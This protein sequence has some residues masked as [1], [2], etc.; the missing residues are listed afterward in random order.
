MPFFN[1]QN[2]LKATP[3][4]IAAFLSLNL[5][6]FLRERASNSSEA[7]FSE[8][9]LQA[10]RELNFEH[11]ML[12]S[13]LG[14]FKHSELISEL[15]QADALYVGAMETDNLGLIASMS[16]GKTLL[17]QPV[18]A[19]ESEEL[20]KLAKDYQEEVPEFK[21][22][23]LDQ[24]LSL[25][26]EE[27]FN[28]ESLLESPLEEVEPSQFKMEEVKV[29]VID[30]GVDADHEIFEGRT[31]LDGLNTFDP[32]Q[33]PFDDVG[34]GTHIAGI[35]ASH[36]PHAVIVPY[37]I[38]GAQ[39]GRLSNVLEAM[40]QAIEDGVNVMNTSFGVLSPSYALEEAIQEA[41]EA[42][43]IVVSA[44]GNNAN[45]LGFY[46]ATYEDSIAV[47]SVN[48]EGESLPRSNYGSW[49]DVAANG[50]F[51]RSSIP[52]NKYGP[53]TGTSQ[54]TAR[55]SAVVAE[56]FAKNGPLSIQD[57]MDFFIQEPHTVQ[58]G[59]LAGLPIVE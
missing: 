21:E 22:V 55:V 54:A 51:V 27:D 49:V 19:L 6:F 43:I 20:A 53:K 15:L 36:S 4:L 39:G 2:L 25:E 44:A 17:L 11:Q 1:R 52:G 5:I 37:K 50:Y 57:V 47:G 24:S 12:V 46:P 29:A 26:A 30:S 34:H 18:H 45:S 16:G 31:V 13:D 7:S 56:L 23:E 8:E 10:L 41:E 48:S 3:L 42:G 33:K 9:S 38:V 58:E 28:L 32:S 35:I 14:E 40:D 59:K